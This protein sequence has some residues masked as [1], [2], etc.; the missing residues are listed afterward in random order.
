MSLPYHDLSLVR[1]AEDSKHLQERGFTEVASDQVGILGKWQGSVTVELGKD[2][3]LLEVAFQIAFPV[4]YPWCKP[5]CIPIEPAYTRCQHQQPDDI[6]VC[7]WPNRL[8]IWEDNAGGW[9]PSFG[10]EEIIDGVRQWVKATEVGWH[11]RSTEEAAV[12]DP[13]RY[14]GVRNNNPICFTRGL[15]VM[16]NGLGYLTVHRLGRCSVVT[17]V[18]DIDQ[19]VLDSIKDLLGFSGNDSVENV[20]YVLLCRQPRFPLFADMKGL[21][22]ELA[23]Q[24]FDR[25]AIV[26]HVDRCFQP[27]A[28]YGELC[29]AYEVIGQR[30]AFGLRYLLKEALPTTDRLPIPIWIQSPLS[31]AM[32]SRFST[33]RILCLDSD[34]LLRRNPKRMDNDNL[35]NAAVG[36]IGLGSIGSLVAELLAKAGVDKLLLIDAGRIDVGNIIRHTVGLECVGQSKALAVRDRLQRF[37]IDGSFEIPACA[38]NGMCNVEKCIDQLSNVLDGYNVLVDC[39]ANE[40]VQDYLMRE[41]IRIGSYYCRVQSYQ[42]GSIGEV[43]IVDPNGPCAACIEEKAEGDPAYAMSGLPKQETAISE[44][45]ASVTQP[46]S[47]AD[48]A[49]ICGIAVE[50]IVDLL[51]ERTLP[52]NLRYWVARPILGVAEDSIFVRGPHIY[53]VRIDTESRCP[54]CHT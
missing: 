38:S 35:R 27:G 22:D 40:T 43:I 26:R 51:L 18:D 30:I 10:L 19:P 20:P 6:A 13:E 23:D 8:C 12:F 4:G 54:I 17:R 53:N 45:C 28:W 9:D 11:T 33:H 37:R 44:G 46:A 3:E 5:H 21:L 39:T 36:V 1:Y 49:V 41:A 52:W 48:L 47:A 50:G 14:F 15:G 32:G 16:L 31:R 24:G 2:K 29:V 25:D 7:A 42:G 34:T